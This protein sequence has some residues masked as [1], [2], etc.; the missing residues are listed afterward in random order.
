MVMSAGAVPFRVISGRSGATV[1]G[2]V[3]F[4]DSFCSVRPTLVFL[5][6]VEMVGGVVVV[7]IVVVAV[8]VG[9]M[10]GLGIVEGDGGWGMD[11]GAGAVVLLAEG[12]VAF[13]ASVLS[14][15]V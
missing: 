1:V 13:G 9:G 14:V 15:F 10:I 5:L 3:A 8:V 4:F 7:V 11:L 6:V 12:G 2:D